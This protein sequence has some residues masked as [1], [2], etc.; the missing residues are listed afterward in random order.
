MI[1]L[2]CPTRPAPFDGWQSQFLELLP[3]VQRRASWLLRHWRPSDREEA[4]AEITAHATV[5]YARLAQHGHVQVA[6]ASSLV[7]YALRHLRA[8]RRVGTPTNVRDLTSPCCRLRG[9][10]PIDRLDRFD[11]STGA[12][13]D[14]VI[15]DRRV[16]PSETAVARLDLEAWLRSLPAALR[17]IAEVLATGERP[18]HVARIT[19]LSPARVSQ[20]RRQLENSWK[21]FQG[22]ESP[23]L[24][25]A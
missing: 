10:P 25:T 24:R 3:A 11:H 12:W 21:A 8:G 15:E 4:L 19:G 13:R 14:V 6:S 16:G 5:A 18:S 1:A 2:A 7:G 20:L 23:A 17:R 22:D 9:R